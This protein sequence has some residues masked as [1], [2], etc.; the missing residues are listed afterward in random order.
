MAQPFRPRANALLRA[1]VAGALLLIGSVIFLWNRYDWGT[2]ETGRAVRVEQPVPFSHEHHVGGLGID[3]RYCHSSVDES[4]FAGM[5]ST[6]TCMSCHSQ[7]WTE[8]EM[9]E[10]VRSSYRTNRP[11]Q[12]RRVYNLPDYVYFDHSAHVNKG[13]ACETCHGRVDR[14]PLL[15]QANTLFMEWCLEC[16]RE[17]ERYLR[18]PEYVYAFGYEVPGEVQRRLGADL[19]DRF[20]IHKEQLTQCSVCHQ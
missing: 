11:I 14:M 6:H 18:P 20:D 16:H 13:V 3:C 5:P 10:P 7:I 2:W 4:D 8:A 17:P 1:F 12:W 15:Y 19:V 9:L